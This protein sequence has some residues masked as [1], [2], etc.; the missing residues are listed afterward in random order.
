M[1]VLSAFFTALFGV[2]IKRTLAHIANNLWELNYIVNLVSCIVLVPF[3]FVFNEHETIA[4]YD[5]LKNASFWLVLASSGLLGFL[6]GLATAFQIHMISP[7]PSNISGV[8]KLL[9][10]TVLGVVWFSERKN[11]PWWLS[12]LVILAGV[13]CYTIA[14]HLKKA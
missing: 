10:T 4:K 2:E 8:A 6:L 11:I 5:G 3:I 12:N 14:R 13:V 7:L 1:G 9:L